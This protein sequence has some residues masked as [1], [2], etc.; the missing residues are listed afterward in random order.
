MTE[1]QVEILTHA[2]PWLVTI[3]ASATAVVYDLRGRRIPNRLTFPLLAGGLIWAGVVHGLGGAGIAL[4][5][6]LLMM[7]PFVLLWLIGGAGA[8][9]AK[10]IGAIAAWLGFPDAVVAVLGVALAGGVLAG[11]YLLARRSFAETGRNFRG[12][13]LGLMCLV[14][15][16]GSWQTRRAMLPGVQVQASMPYAVAILAGT[17]A[18]GGWTWLVQG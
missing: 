3:G 2:V 12:I 14:F 18:A 1:T 11:G 10:L 6:A 4:L 5:A 13:G 9:D 8:G 16:R 7:S 15:A 17:V